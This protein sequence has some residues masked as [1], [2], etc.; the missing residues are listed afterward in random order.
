MVIGLPIN[1]DGTYGSQSEDCKK[2]GEKIK[3]ILSD[4]DIIFEDERLT[5]DYA[6]ERLREK[7]IDYRKDKSLV[8][9]ESACVI[10]E[11]YLRKL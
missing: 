1:M 9:I 8:E 3:G 5:S 6:E 10:L 7:K 4:C 2:F 11:Q